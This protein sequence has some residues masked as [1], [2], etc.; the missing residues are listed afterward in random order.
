[1]RSISSKLASLCLLLVI[2]CLLQATTYYSK[3]SGNANT[4]SNW[5]INSNGTGTAPGSFSVSGDVFILR[6]GVT[7]NLNGHWTISSGVTLQID[8]NLSVTSNNDDITISG[9]VIFTNPG[10]TQVSLTGGG[11]GNDF[12]VSANATIRTY[13]QNGLRGTNA[14]LPATASGSI[15]LNANA[16]YEFEGT[17]GQMTTGLPATVK[18][19]II[20]NST[21]VNLSAN[22]TITSQLLLQNGIL[23]IAS[24]VTLIVPS[25]AAIIG[26]GYGSVKHINTKVSGASKSYIRVNNISGTV[27]IPT[28]GGSN[29]LPVT[30]TSASLTTVQFNVFP[31][32]TR[33]GMP[34]GVAFSTNDK[35][36]AVDAVYTLQ[37]ISGSGSFDLTL[38]WPASLE[39]SQFSALTNLEIGIASNTGSS[40]GIPIG[41]GNQAANTA[42]VTGIATMGVFAVGKIGIPLY[43][44]F[45]SITASL[46]NNTVALKWETL[47]EIDLKKFVI[48]RSADGAVFSII[49]EQT[50]LAANYTGY[51]YEYNDV[52]PLTAVSFYRIRAV[53]RDGKISYSAIVRISNSSGA[54]LKLNLYPNPV[55]NKEISIQAN[56]LKQGIYQVYVV[57]FSGK[58]LFTEQ[59]EVNSSRYTRHILLPSFISKGSYI[60]LLKGNSENM[61]RIFSVQ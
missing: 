37:R 59:F 5:G 1:M 39:G 46:R 6:S 11:N 51:S 31:G 53:D 48:E 57:D 56:E 55:S 32:L 45:G 54:G 27:T 2:P 15:N 58:Q 35:V 14:S 29:Y 41:S 25:P 3:S 26:S 49:S 38:G 20:N 30:I 36:A 4:L 52:N 40:W 23:D 42:S 13:N 18:D 21:S 19:L 17:S 16:N 43:V 33:N 44:K 7:M 24:G 47:T 8:G 61:S 60:L 28:G 50:A 9:T 12:T 10:N 22:T 34:N